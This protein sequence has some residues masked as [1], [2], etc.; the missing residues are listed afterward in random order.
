MSMGPSLCEILGHNWI[1]ALTYNRC[2]RCG[3]RQP[4]PYDDKQE[5][6]L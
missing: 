6:E 3:V 5:E 2:S 1:C 4:N